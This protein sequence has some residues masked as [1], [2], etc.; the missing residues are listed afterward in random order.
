M[1]NKTWLLILLALLT[2]A[3]IFSCQTDNG[4]DADDADDDDDNDNEPERPEYEGLFDISGKDDQWGDYSGRGELRW[5][6]WDKRYDVIRLIE[7]SKADFEGFNIAWAF[8]GVAESVNSSLVVNAELAQIGFI[9]SY[10]EL[11]RE[12]APTENL[13]LSLELIGDQKRLIVK[14]LSHDLRGIANKETW[15]WVSPINEEPIWK[16]EREP[17]RVHQAPSPRIRDT[18][19]DLFAGYH[20]R[21]ELLPYLDRQDFNQAIH[22]FIRDLT[23]YQFSRENPNTLRVAQKVIDPISLAETR[24]RHLAFRQTLAEKAAYYDP[25]MEKFHINGAGLLAGRQANTDPPVFMEDMSSTLWTGVYIQSQALRHL[26]TGESKALDN[27]LFCLRGLIL[28]YDI[29]PE[30]GQFARSARPHDEN[31][32]SDWQRGEG[33]FADY[34]YLPGGNNDMLH[35]FQIGFLFGWMALGQSPEHA[36]L[37]QDMIRVL[38]GL[39]AG[40]DDAHDGLINEMKMV[41]LLYLFTGEEQYHQRYRELWETFY[42][43]LFIVDLGNGSFNI[44]GIS[45]WSGNHLNFQ[46]MIVLTMAAE[47]VD[48]P[49]L[50]LFKTGCQSAVEMMQNVSLGYYQLAMSTLSGVQSP[51][52]I[53][54]ALR[55]LREFPAP[56]VHTNID[57]RINPKFSMSPFPSLPW[58][59]D[60]GVPGSPRLASLY[61]FPI[62]EGGA[63]NFIWR[64]SPFGFRDGESDMEDHSADYLAAYWFARYF[65]LIDSSD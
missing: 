11:S 22:Y 30:L 6:Q 20:A 8:T 40:H 46:S 38:E 60:W 2:S 44:Y 15:Q 50:E 34:D 28:C 58:K 19:F 33:A 45:D 12:G 32:P 39:L 14:N 62:Y 42:L 53:E 21:I 63:D 65:N 43:R 26:V 61:S 4:D 48:D 56:K 1:F 54:D 52:V 29:V 36:P 24:L 25:N 31:S 3:L 41:L 9:T 7:L 49:D 35:G 23:D 37:K 13:N 10:G 47:L 16:S 64:G 5:N 59:F 18:L 55:R 27:L 51:Q 57:W 17:V